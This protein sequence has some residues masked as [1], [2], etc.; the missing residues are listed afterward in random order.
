MESNAVGTYVG[1]ATVDLGGLGFLSASADNL[2]GTDETGTITGNG[3][4]LGVTIL[5]WVYWVGTVARPR[6]LRCWP[7]ARRLTR[8]ARRWRWTR[9]V[10]H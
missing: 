2:V 5:G 10:T 4:L 1:A 9:M 8:G 3:N 6:R 7:T